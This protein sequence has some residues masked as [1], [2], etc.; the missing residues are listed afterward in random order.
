MPVEWTLEMPAEAVVREYS[1]C[2]FQSGLPPF[3]AQFKL[4]ARAYHQ[5]AS[6]DEE[7]EDDDD[8]EP[9][10][11]EADRLTE[12]TEGK[13]KRRNMQE[14]KMN[15]LTKNREKDLDQWTLE[16]RTGDTGYSGAEQTQKARYVIMA[17]H[18]ETMK[19]SV[20]PVQRWY[21]FKRQ[22]SRRMQ[23]RRVRQWPKQPPP[24]NR[25]GM[26]PVAASTSGDVA[27][28]GMLQKMRDKI[29]VRNDDQ[30]RKEAAKIQQDRSASMGGDDD[31]GGNSD[32]DDGMDFEADHSDDNAEDRVRGTVGKRE[33]ASEGEGP[34]PGAGGTDAAK[35]G[36]RYSKNS[37]DSDDGQ[38]GGGSR[39]PRPDPTPLHTFEV[40]VSDLSAQT[41]TSRTRVCS[42]TWLSVGCGACMQFVRRRAQKLP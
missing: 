39:C 7:D 14:K 38:L 9:G 17:V 16:D 24:D 35:V 10:G 26:A 37:S 5:D 23:E 2:R 12:G 28:G 1:A 25:P 13:F 30:G 27:G 19:V 18:K 41:R 33:S 36:K 8:E 20:Y 32:V 4:P 15:R 31:D 34:T 11:S 40:S 29:G 3:G 6:D 42:L 22:N 21:S